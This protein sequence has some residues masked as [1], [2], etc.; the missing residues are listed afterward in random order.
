MHC[1]LN[2]DNQDGFK[3]DP[4]IKD[5]I[6]Q[7]IGELK[8]FEIYETE[9]LMESILNIES[10]LLNSSHSSQLNNQI[11]DLKGAILDRDQTKMSKI[12]DEITVLMNS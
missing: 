4:K 2:L 7:K 11:I 8:Q 1:P 5:Q 6:I 9:K 10:S 3:V 12:S